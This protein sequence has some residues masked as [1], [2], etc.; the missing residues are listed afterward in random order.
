MTV[1][2]AP[3]GPLVQ[4]LR[5]DPG[6]AGIVGARVAAGGPDPAWPK[7]DPRPYV[8][9]QPMTPTRAP[10]GPGS[11]RVGLVGL[12]VMA[13]CFGAPDAGDER[14]AQRTS[15]ELAGAVSEALHDKKPRRVGT[16]L[17]YQAD[18]VAGGGLTEE[19]DTR[20]P[21]WALMVNVIAAAQAVA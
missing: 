15:A 14:V 1:Q 13:K 4:I 19:L 11:S 6:V 21:C 12:L 3:L 2:L 10:F 8:V 7:P 20:R 17:I 16:R 18:Q 9:L 5:S